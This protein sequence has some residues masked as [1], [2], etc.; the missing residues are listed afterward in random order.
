[1][2]RLL[3]FILIALA[4]GVLWLSYFYRKD[5]HDPEPIPL[6]VATFLGGALAVAPAIALEAPCEIFWSLLIQP[7]T[8]F[9][10]VNFFFNVALVEEG[11]KFALV[12]FFLY[13]RRDFDEPVDGVIYASA[14]ALG[15]A[16]AENVI[17]MFKMG[18]DIILL[19]GFLTTLAHVLFACMWGIA[20]GKARFI[21]TGKKRVILQGLL[22]AILAHAAYDWLLTI[23]LVGGLLALALLMGWMWESTH[24]WIVWSLEH[25]PFAPPVVR[26]TGY[27]PQSGQPLGQLPED[28]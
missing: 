11:L 19:R 13:P 5:R 6:V 25:S 7:K 15:F 14:A 10:A 22:L 18:W 23:N 12:F 27:A 3:G 1:M 16:S 24:R 9:N 20:L 28:R 4:P 8:L 26:P 21:D 2:F 17:Y